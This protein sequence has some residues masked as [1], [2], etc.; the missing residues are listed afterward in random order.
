M[1]TQII[2]SVLQN[3]GSLSLAENEKP[4]VICALSLV[5][6]MRVAFAL[7]WENVQNLKMLCK[8]NIEVHNEKGNGDSYFTLPLVCILVSMNVLFIVGHP[9]SLPTTLTY[10]LPSWFRMFASV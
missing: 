8:F 3:N 1:L 4:G 7:Q 5:L 9:L 2:I 6:N 10:C